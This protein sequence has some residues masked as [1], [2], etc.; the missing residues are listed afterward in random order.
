MVN[1]GPRTIVMSQHMFRSW[2]KVQLWWGGLGSGGDNACVRA[3]VCG[4]AP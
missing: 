2:S 4:N 1:C 3:G